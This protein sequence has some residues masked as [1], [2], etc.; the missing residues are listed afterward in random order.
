MNA[1]AAEFSIILTLHCDLPE[2]PYVSSL[3]FSLKHVPE[4]NFRVQPSL[5]PVVSGWIQS[6][7]S[8]SLSDY[9]EPNFLGIDIP[10]WLNGTEDYITY[11]ISSS[12]G[13]E[14]E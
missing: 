11:G 1:F 5:I 13:D 12:G 6:S 10:A 3:D 7:V 4:L 14:Q 2:Y 8:S 9:L